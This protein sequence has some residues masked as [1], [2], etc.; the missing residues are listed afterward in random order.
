MQAQQFGELIEPSPVPF[1]F[2]TPG[3]YVTGVLLLLA[4]LWGVWRYM[5]YRRRNRYRQEALRWL[6]ERMVVLH[7]QQEFMQQLYEADMLMKQ[8]AMQLYGREKVAPLRGGEWIRFL[9][10]QTR[11][12]D[13]FSTDDGLLLTDTMYRKPHAVSAAETDRF[14]SKTSNWI[15]FH[16]HA[17]GNRL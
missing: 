5:R 12:R 11:R 3:W 16:K 13:D 14:I 4:L 10:Q 17:P 2:N 9:N 7:A 8:I 1:S 15:R 6:G